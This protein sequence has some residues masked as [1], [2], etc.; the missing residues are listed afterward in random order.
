MRRRIDQYYKKKTIRESILQPCM[1]NAGEQM[2]KLTG[3]VSFASGRGL[4]M[5]HS[6]WENHLF[7]I[8]AA[9]LDHTF[10]S[11][12]FWLWLH[13]KI[14]C[15]KAWVKI[16]N[17]ILKSIN[18]FYVSLSQLRDILNNGWLNGFKKSSLPFSKRTWAWG[19]WF[20]R[21]TL[22]HPRSRF[23]GEQTEE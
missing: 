17:S 23:M 15:C 6:W 5:Y 16:F 8:V 1:I 11:W 22:S 18:I 3:P 9:L 19:R 7:G 10:L 14:T 21:L 4:Q 13:F 2:S 12:L 20:P